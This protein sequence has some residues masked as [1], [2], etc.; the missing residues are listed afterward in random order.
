MYYPT[1][2]APSVPI[3]LVSSACKGS[4]S[5]AWCLFHNLLSVNPLQLCRQ[6]RRRKFH[7]V[8]TQLNTVTIFHRRKKTNLTLILVR[9]GNSGL[10][11]SRLVMGTMQYGSKE[12]QPWILGED[13]AV[14][15]IKA[16]YVS[17]VLSFEFLSTYL[18]VKLA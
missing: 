17:G 5:P 9:L 10:K 8:S 4:S 15:H 13:E 18:A 14:A 12:W 16:A 6:H 3:V 2:L 11:I 7:T 1:L